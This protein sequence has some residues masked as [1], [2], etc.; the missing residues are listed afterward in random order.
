MQDRLCKGSCHKDDLLLLGTLTGACEP[1]GSMRVL[2]LKYNQL[3]PMSMVCPAQVLFVLTVGVNIDPFRGSQ[4]GNEI[5]R[6][7][8]T[9]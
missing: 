3:A 4:V 6:V 2:L 9:T 7:H 1:R 8:R 5:G